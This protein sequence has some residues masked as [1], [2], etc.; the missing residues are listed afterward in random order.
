MIRTER[1]RELQEQRMAEEVAARAAA[2]KELSRGNSRNRH[3]QYD[4]ELKYMAH[5]GED[6]IRRE[7]E[8]ELERMALASQRPGSNGVVAFPDLLAPAAVRPEMLEPDDPDPIGS[9]AL[10]Q[11]SRS[12]AHHRHRQPT[13]LYQAIPYGTVSQ[14]YLSKWRHKK[15]IHTHSYLKYIFFIMNCC[16]TNGNFISKMKSLRNSPTHCRT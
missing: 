13:Q 4:R 8:R 3:L 14:K 9:S 16:V 5:S 10:R 15:T 11:Y 7:R 6:D 2:L 12:T 1:A